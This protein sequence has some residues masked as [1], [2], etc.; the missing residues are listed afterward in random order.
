M[1]LRADIDRP[2]PKPSS[3]MRLAA[4]ISPLASAFFVRMVGCAV[5]P[6]RFL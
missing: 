3:R 1:R 4:A 6:I 5:L 2:L